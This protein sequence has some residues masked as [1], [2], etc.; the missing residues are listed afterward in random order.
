MTLNE[1]CKIVP[2]ANDVQ[3]LLQGNVIFGNYDLSQNFLV[4]TIV[5]LRNRLSELSND[6][7][8][9]EVSAYQYMLMLTLE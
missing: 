8:L 7:N 4:V 2:I 5:D 6:Y 3:I 9:I 1:F